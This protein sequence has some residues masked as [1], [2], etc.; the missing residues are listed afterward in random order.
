LLDLWFDKLTILSSTLR[1]SSILSDLGVED[2][3]EGSLSKDRAH[4]KPNKLD[5]Y[6]LQN[7]PPDI[8]KLTFSKELFEKGYFT[9]KCGFENGIKNEDSQLRKKVKL[10]PPPTCYPQKDGFC[11]RQIPARKMA[12]RPLWRKRFP[13]LFLY[14]RFGKFFN[15]QNLTILS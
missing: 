4:K 2:R 6:K 5:N 3:P 12:G 10:P 14:R 11:Q 9:L 7:I 15:R 1:L 8:L 13:A